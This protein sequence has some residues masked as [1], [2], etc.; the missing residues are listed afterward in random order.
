M[1][2]GNSFVN[3]DI[4]SSSSLSLQGA[5][6]VTCDA[7]TGVVVEG[8]RFFQQPGALGDCGILA[9]HSGPYELPGLDI[10]GNEFGPLSNLGV[11]LWGPVIADRVLDNDFHDISTYAL[12][13]YWYFAGVGLVVSSDVGN[14][15][16]PFAV[17]R[18]ARG[19]T[20]FANDIGVS[21]RSIFT[22]LQDPSVM[23]DFGTAADPG[24]NTF[25]C[26]S[27]P[28]GFL[29]SGG[30]GPGAD[31]FIYFQNTQAPGVAV[32]FEGNVWDHA[33]PTTLVGGNPTQ[34]FDVWVSG[35]PSGTPH[36]PTV[37]A[38]NSSAASS[39][40]CPSGRP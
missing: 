13:M 34:E 20:F 37:D 30:W 3:L 28:P 2:G 14:V 29:G 4:P 25:R 26:N 21:I 18:R 31:V 9:I 7:V 38:A 23:S 39:P 33:P 22:P 35:E 24:K 19:N 40:P 12:P 5:G 8:N 32:P 11:L 27:E 15:A 17:V 6:L 10:E 36:G 1:G 16:S